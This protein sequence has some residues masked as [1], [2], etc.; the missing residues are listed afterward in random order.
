[1]EVQVLLPLLEEHTHRLKELEDE[2]DKIKHSIRDVAKS[3]GI[4]KGNAFSLTKALSIDGIKS[5]N[6]SSGEMEKSSCVVKG[7]TFSLAKALSF[8]G[9]ESKGTSSSDKDADESN[10]KRESYISDNERGRPRSHDKLMEDIKAPTHGITNPSFEKD[11][12]TDKSSISQPQGLLEKLQYRIARGFKSSETD[13]EGS[14]EDGQDEGESDFRIV[15][16]VK[17]KLKK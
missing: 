11:E 16:W 3:R 10:G 13:Y 9:V 4:S 6:F 5:K 17:G 8:A 2:F 7:S 12:E 1:M 14:S 15:K